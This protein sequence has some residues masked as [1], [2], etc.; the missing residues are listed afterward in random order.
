MYYTADFLF[1]F[2][3][4]LTFFIFSGVMYGRLDLF[5]KPLIVINQ[6]LMC[7]Y[8]ID[9][10]LKI[11]LIFINTFLMEHLLFLIIHFDYI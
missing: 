7:F 6:Q 10:G 8:R 3:I 2:I 4:L 11:K 9:N 1:K 5:D